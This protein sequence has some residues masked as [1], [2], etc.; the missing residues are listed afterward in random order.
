MTHIS[1]CTG[2][3]CSERHSKYIITRLESDIAK[4]SPEG[5]FSV[6]SCI[7]RG[8]CRESPTVLFD[9]EE[10]TRMNPIK[11]SEV[12]MKRIE[13]YKQSKKTV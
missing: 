8:N 9:R 6:G 12:L 7:C 10:M 5:N 11:A 1:V 13:A 4:F 2:K 3:A